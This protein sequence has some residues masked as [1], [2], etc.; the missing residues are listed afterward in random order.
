M[1][2]K[3]SVEGDI[4]RLLG[5]KIE[6]DLTL[7]ADTNIVA[8]T[9]LDSVSVM[10]FVFELEDEFGITVPLDRISDVKTVGQLTDAI[11]GLMEETA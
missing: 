11:Y 6:S 10:D 1:A 8:D 5:E 7:T 3:A 9:G 2:T 4:I